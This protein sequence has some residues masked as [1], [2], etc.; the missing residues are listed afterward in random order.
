MR[1]K[2]I[3]YALVTLIG[4][5]LILFL[6]IP[7]VVVWHET[8]RAAQPPFPVS[9]DPARKLIK[10]N[11][12]ADALFAKHTPLE[13]AAADATGVIEIIGSYIASTPLYQ[14]AA[15]AASLPDMVTINPGLRKEQVA[16]L[17]AKRLGWDGASQKMFLDLPPVS[18]SDL[19]EGTIAPGDY[20]ISPGDSM[21][22]VQGQVRERFNDEVL[23]RYTPEIQKIVPL[24]EGLTIA[25]IIERE[26]SNPN[27]MRIISGIIWNRLFQGMKLQMDSTLQYAKATGRGAWWPPVR[28]QDKYIDSPYNTYQNQ[29]LPPGPIAEP[30][31]SAVLAALNPISTVCFYYFY[32]N[33]GGFHCSATYDAHVAMLKKYFGQ[34]R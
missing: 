8:S 27:E 12:T 11:L 7:S 32:D 2:R 34:G 6:L 25:S 5:S 13:A 16:A 20:S 26:T 30:S 18:N 33:N 24:D 17:F 10:S 19:A 22:A 1:Q 28:P 31:T 23:S 21:L 4:V 29:G 14:F 3:F 15:A 9:V